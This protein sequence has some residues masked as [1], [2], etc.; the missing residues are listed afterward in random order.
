MQGAQTD[1]FAGIAPSRPTVVAESLVVPTSTLAAVVSS[2]EVPSAQPTLAFKSSTTDTTSSTSTSASAVSST[3]SSAI[4]A[5]SSSAAPTTAVSSTS[6]TQAST[7][8][9]SSA[10]PATTTKSTGKTCKRRLHN[11]V[12]R[13]AQ[14]HT[15]AARMAAT[16][17]NVRQR[18]VLLDRQRLLAEGLAIMARSKLV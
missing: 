18:D 1:L 16:V 2:T 14:R 13:V 15:R 9:S 8:V 4:V 6:S 5:S 3:S 7:S 17:E 11:N 10:A 12:V